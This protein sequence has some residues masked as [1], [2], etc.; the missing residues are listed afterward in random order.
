MTDDDVER[1]LENMLSGRADQVDPALSGPELRTAAAV[2][3]SHSTVRVV[4]PILAAAAVLVVAIAPQLLNRHSTHHAPQQ[5]P[6][7]SQTATVPLPTPAPS[8][9]TARPTPSPTRTPIPSPT[10]AT[11]TRVPSLGGQLLPSSSGTP[12]TTPILTSG[13]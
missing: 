13:S 12:P 9:T 2:R 11:P 4:G 8:P 6:G 10:Q 7:S 5:Q 3:G 1:R